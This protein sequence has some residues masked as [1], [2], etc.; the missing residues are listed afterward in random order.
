M[1]A[2]TD[3]GA[4]D[5]RRNLAAVTVATFIGFTGFTL[6]MPF[7]P[8]YFEQLGV[9]DT[10]AIAVWSGVSL[11]VTPAVTA[12]MAPVWARVAERYGRKLMVARS[13]FSFVVIMGAMAYV[14][15]PWQVFALRAVQGFFAGYGMLALTMAAESAP[16]A[17]M[18]SAI[19]WVQTA[20][21][22]GPALGPA[23]GGALA[24]AFG[25]RL[26]FL[27]AAGL[28][29]GAFLLVLVGYSE[30]PARAR[31]AHA[32]AGVRVTLRDLL[33]VPHFGL[34]LAMIFSLQMVD[35]SFGPVLPL[36]LI[37]MGTPLASV[38]VVAGLV[39]T[40]AAGAAAVGNQACAWLMR[41][42][43]AARL[44]MVSAGVA[45]LGAVVFSAGPG[46]TALLAAAAIFGFGIGVSFTAIY[47]VA[48]QRVP[49]GSRG[50]AFGYL[51][52]A[53]LSGLALSP[54]VSGFVGA[55]SMRG[56]FVA[57]ALGLAAVAWAVRRMR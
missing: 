22:L 36:Y 39:F 30:G 7:L 44:V 12:L 25:L 10:G 31:A 53:S 34:F 42:A 51:T 21:R 55:V 14:T 9:K 17:Q 32:D 37:E 13:L 47:T 57:D 8:L 6:V 29:L 54:V 15:A 38:P 26:A 20:Q 35:R 56:V 46:S 2:L 49:E 41:Q 48:G 3:A 11:G 24:A 16:T 45:A 19:G 33:T 40:V 50:V 52:T 18:A 27:A 4:P 43:G 5:W 1:P 28:F 23:I